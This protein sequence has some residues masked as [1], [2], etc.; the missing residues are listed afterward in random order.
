M[1][2]GLIFALVLSCSEEDLDEIDVTG[3]GFTNTDLS[4]I[5][6]SLNL[7]EEP[8]NYAKPDLPDHYKS[9]DAHESD[10]TPETNPT[11]NMGATLGRVLFY[12]TNLSADNT[13]SCA[14]CHQQSAAFSDNDKFSTGLNGELTRRNSMGLIN[15]RYY[16]NGRFFWDESAANLEEQVLIPIEDHKEMGISL[17][18]LQ[19]KLQ[20]IG[21]YPVLFKTAF[22]S[23]EVSSDRI[24]KALSQYVRS[25]VSFNSK[26]DKGLVATGSDG[27]LGTPNLP[28]FSELENMGLDIFINRATCVYC[29][30]TG[31]NVN[32]EA[33]NNGLSLN[34]VDQGKGEVTGNPA[35]NALFKVPSLRNIANTA[36]YMHDGRFETLMDVVNHYS[37]NVQAHPNL[38][39]RLTTDEK[40]GGKVLRLGLSQTEKEALVAFL[41]TLTDEEILTDEKYSDPFK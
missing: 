6:Q 16:G 3:M 40:T 2:L 31:Q 23:P 39:F 27:D 11:T 19:T 34:Y 36:P 1:L 5:N 22:G 24:S 9:D 20:E 13:I 25:I 29:H 26:F 4:I 35:H 41:N 18:D 28:N 38:N 15:S 8:F 7:P 14:S 32:D 37:D 33:K 12:D 17:A 21:Y 10:N 30:G